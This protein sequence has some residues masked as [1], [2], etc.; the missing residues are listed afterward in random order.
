MTE[1]K[2][3]VYVIEDEA[4]LGQL[5]RD[6]LNSYHFE[7]KH[8]LSG[9]SAMDYVKQKQPDICIVDLNLPDIDGMEM[10][11]QIWR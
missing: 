9:K 3:L 10:V 5:V 7:A 4:D 6:T 1:K 11:K 8:F 2:A